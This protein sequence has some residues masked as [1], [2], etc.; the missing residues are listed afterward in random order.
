MPIDGHALT[1]RTF[2]LNALSPR[3][4]FY[5]LHFLLETA[6]QSR[7][8][9]IL[10]ELRH[11]GQTMCCCSTSS[12]SSSSNRAVCVPA[13]V[14]KRGRVGG[15]AFVVIGVLLKINQS[16]A[17]L[18][19]SST[20]RQRRSSCT[21][22]TLLSAGGAE[23]HRSRRCQAGGDYLS[24]IGSNRLQYGSECGEF[25]SLF[26]VLRQSTAIGRPRLRPP[27]LFWTADVDV[28]LAQRRREGRPVKSAGRRGN[29]ESG[30]GNGVPQECMCDESRRP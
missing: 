3:L 27:D 1:D 18:L 28:G 13:P 19:H 9:P 10:V 12:S 14:C 17:L 26:F 11:R 4:P 8:C 15:G 16:F 25:F 24:F 20:L 2:H 5:G 7:Y 29:V 21:S 23:P 30:K 22:P 6:R